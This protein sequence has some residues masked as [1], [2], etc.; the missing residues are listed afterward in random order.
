[1]SKLGSRT[2]KETALDDIFDESASIPFWG[3]IEQL[4]KLSALA[5]H[6][7]ETVTKSESP[8]EMVLETW[9]VLDYAV[10]D[11]IV[12]GYGLYRFCQEDFDLRYELLPQ[13]FRALLRF[14]K[15]TVSY[16]SSLTQEP[17]PSDHYPPYIRSSYGFLKYL[18]EN[19]GDIRKRLKEIEAEYFAKQYPEL[20]EQVKQ[21]W[22][23]FYHNPREERIGRVPSGW[24]NVVSNLD[25]DWFDHAEKLNKAR[26]KAAHSHNLSAIAKIFGIT[27]PRT[28]DLVRNECQKL[29]N[30]LLGIVPNTDGPGDSREAA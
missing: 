18:A 1:M 13:S 29:L 23:S 17:S 25:E 30:K 9:L 2:K 5:S 26:N 10:R 16:Q 14:L 7:L 24:L 20:A 12:N 19:H 21:G 11:L 27:G 6:C 4:K 15:D 3:R 22:Q 28:V 8:R